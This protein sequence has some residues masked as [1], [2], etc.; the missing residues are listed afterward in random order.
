MSPCGGGEGLHLWNEAP[1]LTRRRRSSSLAVTSLAVISVIVLVVGGTLGDTAANAATTPV[2]Q[3]QMTYYPGAVAVS[4]DSRQV[5][6]GNLDGTVSIVSAATLAVTGSVN[7]N[8]YAESLRF[9]PD[10]TQVYAPDYNGSVLRIIDVATKQVRRVVL[11]DL[12][13]DWKLES[14]KPRQGTLSNPDGMAFSPD[15]KKAYISAPTRGLV[16]VISTATGTLSTSIDVGTQPAGVAFSPD[17]TRAYVANYL[18][19]TVSVISVATDRVTATI[20]TGSHPTSVAFSPDGSLAYVANYTAGSTTGASLSVITVAAGAV[21]GTIPVG[22]QPTS[23]AFDPSGQSAYVVIGYEGD[24]TEVSV[25]TSTV[26]SST[27]S[28]SY[29]IGLAVAPDRTRAYVTNSGDHRLGVFALTPAPTRTSFRS[30]RRVKTSERLSAKVRV[31]GVAAPTGT[32]TAYQGRKKLA[33]YKLP[34]RKAGRLTVRLPRFTTVGTVR[35][36]FA[37][38]GSSTAQRSRSAARRITVTR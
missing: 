15:G 9:T 33:V 21:T 19:D 12:E 26:L 34:A 22:S 8:P 6:V 11:H 35:L 5:Y 10:G 36:S 23:V 28:G 37:Y 13:E 27:Y 30:D 32:V 14:G 25:A 18:D 4:P 38:S 1:L 17:G 3:V 2:G 20:P 7:M 24:L 29:A 16:H 31:S